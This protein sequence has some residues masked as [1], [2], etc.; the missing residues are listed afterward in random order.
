MQVRPLIEQLASLRFAMLALGL[1]LAAVPWAIPGTAT[2][3]SLTFRAAQTLRMA[4]EHTQVPLLATLPHDVAAAPLQAHDLAELLLQAH[5]YLQRREAAAVGILLTPELATILSLTQPDTV[6][7]LHAAGAVIGFPAASS[8]PRAVLNTIDLSRF[9]D[10]ERA[11]RLLLGL[12]TPHRSPQL[13][14]PELFH[15]VSLQANAAAHPAFWSNPSSSRIPDFTLAVSGATGPERPWYP[16]WSRASGRAPAMPVIPLRTL[17]DQPD[18]ESITDRI[19]LIGQTGEPLLR[20]TAAAIASRL[21][22]GVSLPPDWAGPVSAAATLLVALYL[23][24]FLS[25]LRP[26]TGLVLSL[27]VLLLLA[28]AQFGVF[29]A[30]NEWLWLGVSGGYLV[31]G[32]LVLLPSALRGQHYRKEH[33]ELEHTRLLLAEHQLDQG[34]AA[35]AAQTVHRNATSEPLLA[36]LYRIALAHE[37]RRQYQAATEILEDVRRR[38]PRYRDVTQRLEVLRG[39]S[40][41]PSQGGSM[42]A[43]LIIPGNGLELPDVGRYR[44]ERELGRGGMGVVYLAT[45][46][47]INRQVAIKA[48][49]LS[50]LDAA[51]MENLK[52]RF[53]R[54]AEA[55]GRLNHPGIVTVHD[56]GEDGNLAYI[57]MDYA[58]GRPLS[59]YTGQDTL[60][61]VATVF[62]LLAQAAEALDYAHEQGVIHR[63]MKPANLI[64]DPESE[65]VMITDFG[66]ARVMDSSRTR[67]GA[68]LG[69]PAYMAPEQIA[70]KR[71]DGR[72][73]IFALGVSMYQLLTGSFPF[74]GDSL[75]ALAHQIS[76]GR[77]R[78]VK[79]L[80]AELPAS[81]SRI[82]NRALKKAPGE[83]YARGAEMA[84]ALRRAKVVS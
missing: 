82:V 33:D 74:D 45:D 36:L 38:K 31:L 59:D 10:R 17:L 15:P 34:N 32:H 22:G 76:Q 73:D 84:D 39:V 60:L 69:S 24:L 54:E 19:V 52:E 63:D 28:M 78:S 49:D 51:E 75:A 11:R 12:G 40:G 62:E 42:A 13:A 23:G 55:A 56:A 44:V 80:R 20:E 50:G 8:H 5:G 27:F 64:Y 6:R 21:S 4:P 47:R 7:Q 70:G 30:R 25:G 3:D 43:T 77:H 83:R 48:M 68:L 2:L 58:P 57:A 72:A 61:P 16:V 41:H 1:V 37:K 35:A 53:I 14:V 71:V 29:L 66:V 46:P 18:A 81:A 79:S 26:A 9:A 67:T 65:R